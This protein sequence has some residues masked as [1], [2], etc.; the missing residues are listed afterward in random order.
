MRTENLM[1]H[2]TIDDFQRSFLID[3]PMDLTPCGC[4]TRW[5]ASR[6]ILLDQLW[7]FSW[8]QRAIF[9]VVL[10]LVLVLT[11]GYEWTNYEKPPSAKEIAGEVVKAIVRPPA[12]PQQAAP[13]GSSDHPVPPSAPLESPSP[14][15]RQQPPSLPLP[16]VPTQSRL[17]RFI[18]NCEVPPPQTLEEDIKQKELL[19]KNIQ[20]WAAT[21]GVSASFSEIKDGTQATIEAKTKEAKARFISMGTVP[22]ITKVILEARWID[23]RKVVVAHAEVPKKYQFYSTVKHLIH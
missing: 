1:F 8:R 2:V 13:Q 14:S 20:A 3:G 19:Q 6:A 21:I 11:G 22:G 7:R 15:A 5:S 16:P 18:F 12:E 10:L 17:D 9:S 4:I 23:R